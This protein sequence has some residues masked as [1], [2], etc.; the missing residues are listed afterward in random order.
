MESAGAAPSSF[1]ADTSTEPTEGTRMRHT[2]AT[3]ERLAAEDNES[4]S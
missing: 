3:P 1:G 2:H 4:G